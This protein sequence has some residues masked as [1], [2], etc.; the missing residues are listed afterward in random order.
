[1]CHKIL[2]HYLLI[3]VV[4]NFSYGIACL[5][6]ELAKKVLKVYIMKTKSLLDERSPQGLFGIFNPGTTFQIKGNLDR[7]HADCASSE[8]WLYAGTEYVTSCL[9]S[10]KFFFKTEL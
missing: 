4:L 1:M 7:H 8:G 2:V 9:L 6:P 5:D 10:S 3:N